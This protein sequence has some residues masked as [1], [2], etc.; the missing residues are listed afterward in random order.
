MKM[1][2]MESSYGSKTACA[3]FLAF[4]FLTFA[5]DAYSIDPTNRLDFDGDGKADIAIYR[6]GNPSRV[7]QAYSPSTFWYWSSLYGTWEDEPWGRS[8]D[9]PIPADYTGDNKTDP[10]IFRWFEPDIAPYDGN[11]IWIMGA[12]NRGFG[13]ASGRK[14]GR[15]FVPENGGSGAQKAELGEFQHVNIYY[16][17]DTEPP[18]YQYRLYWQIG[19]TN[20]DYIVTNVPLGQSASTYNQAPVPEDYSG[21]GKS[22]VAVFNTNTGCYHIWYG[23]VNDPFTPTCFG[24]GFSP[25]PGN[26]DRDGRVDYG[27]FKS[28]GTNSFQWQFISSQTNGTPTTYSLTTTWNGDGKS[29]VADYDGDGVVDYAVAQSANGNWQW[30][31]RKSGCPSNINL[32]CSPSTMTATFGLSTD[33][34]LARPYFNDSWY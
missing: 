6:E 18:F 30:T 4:F 14:M 32:P 9:V 31:I 25:A 27:V 11:Y 7:S 10:T 1:P 16:D 26:Y 20:L 2:G 21:D 17:S 23:T 24:S 28:T 29:V 8:L 12:A 19:D 33:T 3:V 5:F 15:N 34:L 22:E 13:N